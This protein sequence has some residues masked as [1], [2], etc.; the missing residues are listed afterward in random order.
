MS[1]SPA[2]RVLVITSRPLVTVDVVHENGRPVGVRRPISL[3]PIGLVRREL[4]RALREARGAVAVRYLARATPAAVQTALL[5]AYDVVHFVGHGAEDGRLLLEGEDATT[6]FLSLER[7]AHMLRGC[8]ARLM[9][10]S[11]CHSGKAAQAL[12]DAGIANVV[13]VDGQFP[14]ADRAAALFNQL[15]YGA[16]L[17]GRTLTDAFQQGVAA[18]RADN[19]VG[20]HHPP[21]DETTGK[22]L[23]SWSSRFQAFFSDERPLVTSA[24]NGGYEELDAWAVPTN[25]PHGP[26]IIGREA[27]MTD[28]IRALADARMVTLNGPGGIGK[29]TVALEVARWHAD[30][31]LFRDGVFFTAL[32]NVSDAD[33]LAEAL[34]T[35][36]QLQLNPANPWGAL[37]AALGRKDVLLLLDNAESLLVDAATDE[38][39][40]AG[41]LS[42][43]LEAAPGL[44]LL[45]TSREELG[46][47]RWER[48]LAVEELEPNEAVRLFLRAAPTEQVNELALLQRARVREICQT[49]EN[50][51][52]AIVIAAAQLGMAGM[53]PARLLQDLREKMLA[54]LADERSRGVPERLRSLRASLDLSYQRLSG[55][56]RVVFFSLGVLP[57]GA[58]G[59]IVAQLVGKRYEPAARELV[60]RN[61]ARWEDGRYSLLAPIRAYAGSTRPPARLTAGQL[62]AARRYAAFADTINDLLKPL[63]RRRIAE[64]LVSQTEGLSRENR[65]RALTLMALSAFDAERVNLLAAVQW[66]SAGNEWRLVQ[67][68]VDKLNTYLHLRSL[69]REMVAAGQL[70]VAAAPAY[71]Q[72]KVG[73]KHLPAE[74]H[75]ADG[76]IANASPLRFVLWCKRTDKSFS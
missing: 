32:E 63:S 47:R 28:V 36:V 7:A 65:E 66:A 52:L 41:R 26:E 9:V 46:L 69:W 17:R 8:Q 14:I 22:P 54:V 50:Y 33:R 64:Q 73:A 37:Q 61:L 43:L 72:G 70:A 34:A 59:Q 58:S 42:R 30:R 21:L 2:L 10:I 23:P 48:A 3:K 20:D 71:S 38:E 74:Y 60:A 76:I 51:P 1:A 31:E 35:A 75:R 55:R 11:A 5:D 49:L 24:G 45:V 15:F 16:L 57:C 67:D 39:S 62:R 40:S 4:A 56:A 6:D 13:A 18:V 29:T 27:L 25:L 53:T 12:R 68:L 19:E 44:K